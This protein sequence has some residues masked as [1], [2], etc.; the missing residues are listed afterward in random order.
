[1]SRLEGRNLGHVQHVADVEARARDLDPAEAVDREVAQRMRR[2]QRRER[3]PGHDRG[4]QGSEREPLHRRAF[5]AT[6][7]QTIEKCGFNPR[8]RRR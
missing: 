1:M 8:A 4:R 7:D 5:L 2:R 6:G 3:E